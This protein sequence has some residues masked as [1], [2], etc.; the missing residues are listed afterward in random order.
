MQ[1]W[2]WSW[3]YSCFEVL[4]RIIPH[5]RIADRTALLLVHYPVLFTFSVAAGFCVLWLRN[6][7]RRAERRSYLFKAVSAF[8]VAVALTLIVRPWITWPSPARNPAFTALFPRYL[9]GLGTSDSFPSHSTLAYFVIATGFWPLRRGLS[10]TL[11]ILT[12]IFV[13]LPRVY[14]G[15]HYPVDVVCSLLLGSVALLIVWTWHLPSSLS[16]WLVSEGRAGKIRNTLLFLWIAE[17]ADGFRGTEF[18]IGVL[19]RLLA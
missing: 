5:R 19:R 6:D 9:W 13:S 8:V 4:F 11:S 3:N 14:L 18:V 1:P 17:L 16:R 15:G 10:I 7:A 2:F 12:V